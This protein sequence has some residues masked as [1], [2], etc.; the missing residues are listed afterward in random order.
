MGFDHVH[1]EP[2][3]ACLIGDGAGDCLASPPRGI[4]GKLLA[5]AIVELVHR[6]H[7]TDVALLDQIEELQ[8]AAAVLFGD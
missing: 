3:R 6:F 7:Q 4:G 8:S 2:D 5:S 1:R